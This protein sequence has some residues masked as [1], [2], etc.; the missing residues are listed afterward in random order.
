[1]S[2]TRLTRAAAVALAASATLT[3]CGF[4][5]LYSAP[6]PGGANLGSHPYRVLV[7]FAN[8]LDL[9]PQSSVKVNDVTVGKVESI[10]LVDWH[11]Q[12]QVVVN[13][14]VRLP[15]NA[16][17]QI[18]QTSLL[19]EKFVS[20]S[21][22]P[23]P[24]VTSPVTLVDA[25]HPG[26]A[27]PHIALGRTGSSPEVEEVLGAL[28]LLLNGGGLDQIKTI[29]HEL[30]DALEG[31]SGD[32]RSLLNQLTTMT[33]TL[34]AQKDRVLKAVDNLDV[35][36]K[37]LSKQKQILANALD[38]MPQAVKI[39]AD[40]KDQLVALLTSL[41]NLS[42]VAVKVVNGSMANTVTSLQSL[43]PILTELTKAGA[44]L[45]K[46]LELMATYPFP[47]TSV[48]GIRGD[49][50]NL[51]ITAD[52]NLTDVLSNLTKPA[53]PGVSPIPQKQSFTVGVP[54]AGG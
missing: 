23:Q 30:N 37:T 5:G 36:A 20:L 14:D 29:T 9:V 40:E 39:L 33:A 46:A 13:G 41:D 10:K 11:A 27:H 52:L 19:G 44:D 21:F 24:E 42:T 53:A 12:V 4:H 50:T 45:P 1:M 6:L 43:S 35:L 38:M 8:V 48:N 31:H 7:D 49:Y 18:R 15:A 22:P 16:Y 34:N 32:V 3:G 47:K 26:F 2:V 28:S 54:G 51:V 25:P 17:A